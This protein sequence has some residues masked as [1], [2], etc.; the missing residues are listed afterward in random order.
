MKRMAI[1][2]VII[3]LI[4]VATFFWIKKNTDGYYIHNQG[5]GGIVIDE[6]LPDELIGDREKLNEKYFNSYYADGIPYEGFLLSAPKLKV[7]IKDGAFGR[8]DSVHG[9]SENWPPK[10]KL[11]E[12]T[13]QLNDKGLKVDFIV[14]ESDAVRTKEGL[15][16]GST[17]KELTEGRGLIGAHRVPPSFGGDEYSV[18][19]KGMK[20][21]LFYFKNEKN[22]KGGGGVVRI[23]IRKRDSIE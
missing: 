3:A 7:A 16:V 23:T 21:V 15:G 22:A 6:S 1:V 18:K 8:W 17:L 2:A 4:S 13:W 5:V 10:S 19:L 14:I 9:I 12:E 11:A 20:N